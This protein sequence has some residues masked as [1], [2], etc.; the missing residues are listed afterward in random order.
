MVFSLLAW[1]DSDSHDVEITMLLDFRFGTL[2]VHQFQRDFFPIAA[3]HAVV[4]DTIGLG[5]V[6]A[7]QMGRTIFHV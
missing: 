7:H 6:F 2:E 4:A 1:P 5:L 3:L